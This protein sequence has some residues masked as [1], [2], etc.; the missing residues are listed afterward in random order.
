MQD[1]GTVKQHSFAWRQSTTPAKLRDR[2]LILR[3]EASGSR[4]SVEKAF[5]AAH[6]CL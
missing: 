2:R 3:A 4:R 1:S 5:L 6:A